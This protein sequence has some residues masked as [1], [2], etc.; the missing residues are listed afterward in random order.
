MATPVNDISLNSR[1]RRFVQLV[2]GGSTLGS[3]YSKV[4]NTTTT[5]SAQSAGHRLISLPAPAAYLAQLQEESRAA[6]IMELREKREFLAR[7]VRTPIADLDEASPLVQ[8]V[9]RTDKFGKDGRLVGGT[10]TLK[11]ISKTE[12]IRIDNVLAGHNA[13]ERVEHGLEGALAEIVGLVR[14]GCAG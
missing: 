7:V 1:Q 3:A 11:L 10:T 13:P 4:Y 8:E 14:S 9:R 2:S 5:E 6:T 12:A